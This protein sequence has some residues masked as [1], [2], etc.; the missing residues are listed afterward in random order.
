MF[1]E[2]RDYKNRRDEIER[3]QRIEKEKIYNSLSPADKKILDALC[4]VWVDIAGPS[5]KKSFHIYFDFHA[6]KYYCESH[7]ANNFTF[8]DSNKSKYLELIKIWV[9]SRLQ[10]AGVPWLDRKALTI[11]YFL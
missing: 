8:F 1:K 9:D 6:K 7:S 11:H 3:R 4:N 10:A 2:N 5:G